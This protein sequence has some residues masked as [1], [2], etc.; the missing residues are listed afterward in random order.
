MELVVDPCAASD[1]RDGDTAEL[2]R[3]ARSG[4]TNRLVLLY[5]RLLPA[6]YAWASVRIPRSEMT[7]DDFVQEVWLRAI[8]NLHTDAATDHPFRAW[9]FGIAKNT[10][11]EI[12]RHRSSHRVKEERSGPSAIARVVPDSTTSV[13]AKLARDETMQR[14]LEFAHSLDR[15]DRDMFVHCALEGRSCTEVARQLGLTPEGAIKRWQRQRSRLREL[16]WLQKLL[17]EVA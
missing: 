10:L 11:L 5:E 7:P 2:A 15:V 1:D 14:L 12:L 13:A 16:G 3:A 9:V 17:L 8:R 6:L 4:D